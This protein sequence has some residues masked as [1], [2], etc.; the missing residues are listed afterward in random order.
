MF[1]SRWLKRKK[2]GSD[3]KISADKTRQQDRKTGGSHGK[4]SGKAY[5]DEDQEEVKKKLR[6]L[7]YM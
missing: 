7:G 3:K 4:P 5:S 1:F 6:S 2:S